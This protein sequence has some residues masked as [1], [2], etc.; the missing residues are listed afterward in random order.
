[1]AAG[2][3]EHS[4]KGS[5]RAAAHRPR[6]AGARRRSARASTRSTRSIHELINER[7]RLAQQVGISKH[8]TA[9]RSTSTGP[10]REAQVLRAALERNQGPLRDEE[11]AAAVPRDHVGLP[12]AAGAAE[13]R[14]PR[15]RG[16]LHPGRGAQALRPLG[17]RAAAADRSTRCSTKWRPATPTSASCRSRTPPKAPSTNTLD[18]FLT[19]R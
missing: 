6:D 5:R 10:E 13:G 11:I 7:A 9:T 12:R 2:K 17:A 1:M 16:H 3:Q 8:A 14:L 4:R 18:R 15:A 19:R